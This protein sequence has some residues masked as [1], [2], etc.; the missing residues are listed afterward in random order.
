M[1]EKSIFKLQ[2]G[3]SRE[4]L[5]SGTAFITLWAEGGEA[6]NNMLNTTAP[7]E[8]ITIDENVD[9]LLNKALGGDFLVET[10][11]HK[12]VTIVIE[13]LD[14]YSM[15]CDDIRNGTIQDFYDKWNVHDNKKARVRMGI[16]NPLSSGKA[17]YC[18]ITG[19]RRMANSTIKA[20]GVGRYT[21][22]L[23]GIKTEGV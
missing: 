18:V 8:K 20:D 15:E 21:M 3:Y 19:L 7:A 22:T 4:T 11:G 13:G 6:L 1:S 17:F 9:L 2:G 5:G 14:L 23:V 16:A 10:F 12:P